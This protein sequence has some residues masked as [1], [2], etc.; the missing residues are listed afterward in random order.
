[1]QINV[2]H[3]DRFART[4]VGLALLGLTPVGPAYLPGTHI[5]VNTP[6]N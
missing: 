4:V 1:M 5:G 3:L 2:G 6:C